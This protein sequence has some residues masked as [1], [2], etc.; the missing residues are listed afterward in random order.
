MRRTGGFHFQMKRTPGIAAFAFAL[1]VLIPGRVEAA[2]SITTT[3]VSFGTYDVF[4]TSPVDS[5]GSVRYQCSGSTGTFTISLGTG[6]GSTFQPRTM[7][8]GPNRLSYNLY[9]D[10]A[11]T[12]IWGDATGGTSWFMASVASGKPVTLTVFGRIPP[13]QDV[14]AGSYTDTIIV[15]IQ[16]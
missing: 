11:R 14:A 4:D 6:S 12:S 10:A 9:L 3:G 16:F 15:T 7:G 8:S 5:T 2:C 1:V 13:G